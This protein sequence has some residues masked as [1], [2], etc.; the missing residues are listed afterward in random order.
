MFRR[1]LAVAVLLAGS[2]HAAGSRLMALAAGDCEDGELRSSARAFSD[3]LAN[4]F[5]E[6]V[7][8]A[9]G[10]AQQLRPRAAKSREDIQR[11]LAVAQTQFYNLQYLKAD[12]QVEDALREIERLPPGAERWNLNVAARLLR[13]VIL[14]GAKQNARAEESFRRVLAL[15]PAYQ[16]DV[17]YYA[18]ST[19]A[20]F[21]KVRKTMAAASTGTLQVRASVPGADVYVDGFQAGKAPLNLKL[22]PGSYQVQ[23]MRTGTA[24][25]ARTVTLNDL[26]TVHVDLEFEGALKPGQPLCVAERDDKAGLSA[27]AKLGAILGVDEVVVVRVR[28]QAAAT[29]WLTATLVSVSGA[30]ELRMGGLKLEGTSDGTGQVSALVS[31]VTTGEPAPSVVALDKDRAK[32]RELLAADASSKAKRPAD[33][34]QVV[35]PEALPSTSTNRFA[36]LRQKAWMPAAGGGVLLVGGGVLYGL[37]VAQANALRSPGF[38]RTT[39]AD[40]VSRGRTFEGVGL[41]LAVGG[42]L[43]A[44]AGGAMYL[45]DSGPSANAGPELSLGAGAGSGYAAV[46]GRW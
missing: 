35:A 42:L 7:L 13:G 44:G 16:M 24:S 11:Q 31:Y 32:Q 21:D 14:L 26:A 17:D 45:L 36:G 38:D 41:G 4:R 28:R 12:Q 33:A 29:Q 22:A 46:Q 34:P 5:P 37:A 18:P 2:A 27:A 1:T 23:V 40:T 3:A 30:Q 20:A 15:D 6:R 25:F 8:E 19:R 9:E 39:V 10:A 43:A